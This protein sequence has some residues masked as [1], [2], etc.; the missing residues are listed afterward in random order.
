MPHFCT[1]WPG[2]SLEVIGV[3]HLVFRMCPDIYYLGRRIAYVFAFRGG[4][5]QYC[6]IITSGC[7]GCRWPGEE[8]VDRLR[9]DG[10]SDGF[11]IVIAGALW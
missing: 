3:V 5:V 2:R 1:Q 7:S 4:N 11:R 10:R 9:M 6:T 8:K